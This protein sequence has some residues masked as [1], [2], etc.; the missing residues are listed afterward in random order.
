MSQASGISPGCTLPLTKGLRSDSA[1]DTMNPFLTGTQSRKTGGGLKINSWNRIRV[2]RPFSP[3]LSIGA[4]STYD[5]FLLPS[6]QLKSFYRLIIY[7]AKMGRQN[8]SRFCPHLIWS[9]LHLVQYAIEIK[10]KKKEKKWMPW[11][12]GCSVHVKHSRALMLLLALISQWA[13]LIRQ[14]LLLQAS[15]SAWDDCQRHKVREVGFRKPK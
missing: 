3:P 6:R 4:S 10:Y 12:N 15:T 13:D 11:Q 2:L 9:V 8:V 5:I 1:K 14:M 7:L